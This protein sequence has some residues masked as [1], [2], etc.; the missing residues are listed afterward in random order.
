MDDKNN[1][2][3]TNELH[4]EPRRIKVYESIRRPFYED[5]YIEHWLLK[6]R[7]PRIAPFDTWKEQSPEERNEKSIKM[8]DYL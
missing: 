2:H 6:K 3:D 7:N 8:E 5:G 4:E 1:Q